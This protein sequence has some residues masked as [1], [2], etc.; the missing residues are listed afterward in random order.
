MF[1][2]TIPSKIRVTLVGNNQFLTLPIKVN[3]SPV[4]KRWIKALRFNLKNGAKF[5][6]RT[7]GFGRTK[8]MVMVELRAALAAIQAYQPGLI[9]MNAADDLSREDLNVLHRHFE[10]MIGSVNNINPFF[11][12][13]PPHIKDAI[14][15]LNVKVHEYEALE[16]PTC[17]AQIYVALKNV[18]RF[19][20]KKGDYN[21]F[22]LSQGFGDV[23]LHYAQLGKQ[24]LDVYLD[25]DDHV[26]DDNVR[27][28][29]YITGEFD[30]NFGTNDPS[31]NLPGFKIWLASKGYDIE[32]PSLALGWLKVAEIDFSEP[33]FSGLSQEEI[34]NLVSKY[35]KIHDIKFN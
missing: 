3:N 33:P 7:V 5:N 18:E 35:P 21:L 24:L 4:A 19:K 32:D 14:S 29:K 26:T 28:L 34:V 11:Q 30:L 6:E 25:E 8:E 15:D 16:S 1:F 22:K 20:L 12:N 27:P 31:P 23:F 2:W 10:D 17:Q 13:A 9:K